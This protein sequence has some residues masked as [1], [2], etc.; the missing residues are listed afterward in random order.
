GP[1]ERRR[2]ASR[3]GALARRSSR[4]GGGQ[5]QHDQGP[6]APG[7]GCA[8]QAGAAR[9]G[10]RSPRRARVMSDE[11]RMWTELGRLGEGPLSGERA[12]AEIVAA[13]LAGMAEEARYGRIRALRQLG[14]LEQE[15]RSIEAFLADYPDS[16]YALRLR[17]RVEELRVP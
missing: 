4:D 17:R 7:P 9:P 12:D 1:A 13:A 16:R 15:R 5:P 2:A 8:A 6:P 10:A 3:P 11:A 14:H